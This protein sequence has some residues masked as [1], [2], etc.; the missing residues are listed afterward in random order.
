MFYLSCNESKIYESFTFWIIKFTFPRHSNLLRCTWP[1][2]V[3]QKLT[4]KEIKSKTDATELNHL[5][6]FVQCFCF[7]SFCT[8]P[9]LIISTQNLWKLWIETKKCYTLNLEVLNYYKFASPGVIITV[10]SWAGVCLC[11]CFWQT[12]KL[13]SPCLWFQM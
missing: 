11:F 8:F 7:S 2:F 12:E 4:I 10:P 3:W 9:L 6:T 13:I 5:C 1:T